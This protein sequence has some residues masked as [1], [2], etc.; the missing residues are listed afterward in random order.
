MYANRLL[1]NSPRLSDELANTLESVLLRPENESCCARTD[2]GSNPSWAL[3]A[4]GSGMV[5]SSQGASGG[6]GDGGPLG[7][8]LS[9]FPSDV[10]TA[11]KSG[12]PPI[13]GAS[14][15]LLGNGESELSSPCNAAMIAL[16]IMV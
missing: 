9:L 16:M 3:V 5:G 15:G 12:S 10:G 13:L 4:T 8:S 1:E 2:N 6:G 11:G 14:D 7:S